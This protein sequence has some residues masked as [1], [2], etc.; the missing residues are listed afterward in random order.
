M[1][2]YLYN[3]FL[4]SVFQLKSQNDRESKKIEELF[5]IKKQWVWFSLDYSW[6]FVNIAVIVWGV[7]FSCF[8]SPP[9]IAQR[10]AQSWGEI[11]HL[12]LLLLHE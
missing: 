7:F 5:D 2:D 1:V 6:V 9:I 12:Q 10:L 8:F 3:H 4:P 11:L